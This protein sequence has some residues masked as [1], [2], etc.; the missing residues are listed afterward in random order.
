MLQR[1]T[2]SKIDPILESFIMDKL[3]EN[4]NQTLKITKI[5]LCKNKVNLLS[6]LETL[7][8]NPYQSSHQIKVS[9]N[10]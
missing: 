6:S 4:I 8:N 2:V 10:Y 7:I 5:N 3:L 9:L 1:E